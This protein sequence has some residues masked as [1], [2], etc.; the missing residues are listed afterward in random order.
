MLVRVLGRWWVYPGWWEDGWVPGGTI[1]G[2]YPDQSQ[3]PY[4]VII[5]AL[6]PTHGQ[7]KGISDLLMRFLR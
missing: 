4:L 3:D 2:Y 6:G 7:M 1:P 5:Q